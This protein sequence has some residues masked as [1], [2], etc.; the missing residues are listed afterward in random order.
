MRDSF[1]RGYDIHRYNNCCIYCSAIKHSGSDAE[2]MKPRI[3]VTQ[4]A[5]ETMNA[6]P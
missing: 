1:G 4:D 5:I 2:R 3:D 6:S